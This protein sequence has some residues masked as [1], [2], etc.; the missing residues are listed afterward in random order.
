MEPTQSPCDYGCK[1]RPTCEYKPNFREHCRSL[2]QFE[3]T[4][5]T[6]VAS[7]DPTL[8]RMFQGW[9]LRINV[10]FSTAMGNSSGSVR[11]LH[12]LCYSWIRY[13]RML[14]PTS[15]LS[16]SRARKQ[17]E[18]RGVKLPGTRSSHLGA[19]SGDPLGVLSCYLRK[20]ALM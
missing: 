2:R 1:S 17:K 6:F 4:M 5:G 18:R 16:K 11:T 15:N 7:P 14:H 8:P 20:A 9:W 3:C 12:K 19:V 13:L 10:N